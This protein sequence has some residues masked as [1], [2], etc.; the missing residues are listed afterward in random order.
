MI[1][2]T[3]TLITGGARSGKSRL[4][5]EKLAPYVKKVFL[6][7]AVATDP[8]M[9]H[10]IRRHQAERGPDFVTVEEPIHLARAIR[11]SAPRADAILVDCLT[12]WLNNLFHHLGG[13][14]GVTPPLG[15]GDR[16]PPS[17]DLI[18]K[19]IEDFLNILEE[20]PTTLIVVT[21]EINMGVIPGD[22]RTRQFVDRQGWLNQEVA[23][24]AEEVI[25]MVAGIPQ[26]VKEMRERKIGSG[27]NRDGSI[28]LEKGV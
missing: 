22:S 24:R 7:T 8:E 11:Q 9:E 1:L 16:V 14:E 2:P 27:K 4:A 18:S 10:R 5:R 28:F 15:R 25:L 21:N 6:A 23:R 17:D 19:E 26:I 12:F 3:L 13:R 20:R